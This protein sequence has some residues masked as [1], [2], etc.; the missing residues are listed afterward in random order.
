MA[1]EEAAGELLI[2]HQHPLRECLVEA[3]AAGDILQEGDERGGA[4]LV[5]QLADGVGALRVGDPRFGI[6]EL[7]EAAGQPLQRQPGRRRGQCVVR[8]VAACPLEH[9]GQPLVEPRRDPARRDR[10]H[11]GMGELV[12]Q[13]PLELGGLF[14]GPAH[15]HPDASVV[16][17]R[18]PLR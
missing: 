11:Q 13:D 3:A 15:R 7:P 2:G 8:P 1:G 10:L 14:E 16:G 5:K 17:R 18:R 9:H 6:G 4:G 12:G